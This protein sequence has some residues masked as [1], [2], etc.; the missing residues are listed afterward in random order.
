MTI[1]HLGGKSGYLADKSPGGGYCMISGEWMP[2]D[3]WVEYEKNGS[4]SI[5]EYFPERQHVGEQPIKYI[6]PTDKAYTRLLNLY[7]ETTQKEIQ[8]VQYIITRIG[9]PED[10]K[11]YL[12][13]LNGKMKE[14]CHR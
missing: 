2:Y 6:F 5:R 4:F 11:E 8:L 3:F 9:M 13:W 12:N 1:I 7:K 10:I 14:I